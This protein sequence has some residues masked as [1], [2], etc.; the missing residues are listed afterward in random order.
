MILLPH[1]QWGRW[2]MSENLMEVKVSLTRKHK[3]TFTLQMIVYA[4][5]QGV[6]KTSYGQSKAFKLRTLL[7]KFQLL[8]ELSFLNVYL[9]YKTLFIWK[10]PTTK[11][12]CL[13]TLQVLRRQ[14]VSS[15]DKQHYL[16]MLTK[17]NQNCVHLLHNHRHIF[18]GQRIKFRS[19]SWFFFNIY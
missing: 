18:N 8:P 13:H 9:I 17:L 14:V 4:E 5:F 1:P 19:F 7:V 2:N 6:R 16:R 12:P 10:A 3:L 15:F 11:E